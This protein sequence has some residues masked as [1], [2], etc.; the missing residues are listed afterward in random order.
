MLFHEC[1]RQAL[2]Q[3]ADEIT[4]M[5]Q[6]ADEE[7]NE[8]TQVIMFCYKKS[9]RVMSK[10]CIYIMTRFIKT[11]NTSHLLFFHAFYTPKCTYFRH[12]RIE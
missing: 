2:E 11:V 12:N 6:V 5:Q 7:K 10:Y 3:L 4:D 8:N 9:F 1:C